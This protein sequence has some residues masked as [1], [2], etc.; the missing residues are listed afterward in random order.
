MT[1]STLTVP[2]AGLITAGAR[3]LGYNPDTS[4]W[5]AEQTNE[6][7]DCVDVGCRRFYWPEPISGERMSHGWSFLRATLEIPINAGVWEYDL[8]DLFGGMIGNL[9]FE[10]SSGV[11][12]F[13]L[14]ETSYGKILH[15]R[16]W[17]SLAFPAS[18]PPCLYAVHSPVETDSTQPTRWSMAVWPEPDGPYVLTGEYWINPMQLTSAATYP[19]GG[20]MHAE[21]LRSAVIAACELELDGI[22]GPQNQ[23]FMARLVASI[24]LDRK[25]SGPMFFGYNR[26]N[27]ESRHFM[28]RHIAAGI[29]Y[30]GQYRGGTLPY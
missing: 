25:Q 23:K 26:D 14:K 17:A 13:H 24:N 27:S 21:T 9:A 29:L 20:A 7:N 2:R 18:A 30:D 22:A 16:Q 12:G 11:L 10:P 6:V 8:P 15:K 3:Y 28:P 5:V 19:C 4:G 1:E